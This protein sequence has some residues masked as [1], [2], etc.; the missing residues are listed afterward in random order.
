MRPSSLIEINGSDC[1]VVCLNQ[2]HACAAVFWRAEGGVKQK[3]HSGAAGERGLTGA[4]GKEFYVSLKKF[5]YINKYVFGHFTIYSELLI[6]KWQKLCNGL[7]EN[8]KSLCVS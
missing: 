6:Y 2:S 8:F 3:C 4:L 1:L 7:R 5:K